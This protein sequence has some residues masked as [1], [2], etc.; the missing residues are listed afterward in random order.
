MVTVGFWPFDVKNER[1]KKAVIVTS[2]NFL[3]LPYTECK[4][5]EN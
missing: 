3:F 2:S 4:L 1:R 5:E